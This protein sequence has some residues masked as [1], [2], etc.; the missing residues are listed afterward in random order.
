MWVVDIAGRVGLASIG[1]PLM[2]A[3]RVVVTMSFLLV[4]F[5]VSKLPSGGFTLIS[6]SGMAAASMLFSV[7]ISHGA[8]AWSFCSSYLFYAFIFGAAWPMIYVV[9]PRCFPVTGRA[10]GMAIASCG[11]KLSSVVQ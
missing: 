5:L 9:T 10:T 8:A 6:L 11:A 2:I 4:S 7:V 1:T 3:A